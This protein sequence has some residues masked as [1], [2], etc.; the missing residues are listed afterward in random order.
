MPCR[1]GLPY[2]PAAVTVTEANVT[3]HDLEMTATIRAHAL[4][5]EAL[6]AYEIREVAHAAMASPEQVARRLGDKFAEG[7]RQTEAS[8]LIGPEASAADRATM[9][10]AVNREV[11]RVISSTIARLAATS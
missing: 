2:P 4:L 11:D 5:L 9:V 6:L 7:I 8:K 3:K 1:K 10:A